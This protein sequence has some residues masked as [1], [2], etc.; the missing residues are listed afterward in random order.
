MYSLDINLDILN[1]S[2]IFFSHIPL[3][4]EQWSEKD[5]VSRP[6]FGATEFTFGMLIEILYIPLIVVML[7]KKNFSM[8]C[9]KIMVF[10]ALIDFV[11]V[12][13]SCLMTGF[14]TFQGA[15]FCTYPNLIYISGCTAKCTWTGSCLT[16]MILVIN[17]LLDLSFN[18][19]KNILFDGNRTF[20]ILII[21]FGYA[22]YFLIFNPPIV[23]TSKFHSWFFDPL[24]F[25][26][27]SAEYN[28]I[29]VLFNN[30]LI[31]ITTC[32]LYMFFCCALGAKTKNTKTSSQTRK[33][34]KIRNLFSL[35]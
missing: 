33:M 30:F 5:G 2:A 29:P 27:R 35:W 32:C 31:V 23:F 10:L 16:A 34:V 8:S 14:L 17:R 4:P 28:N 1:G 22:S 13:F 25:E 19:I 3:T 12:I 9:Y 21:P 15:V 7:E 11:A 24:I 26:G 20:L 6:I 18:R